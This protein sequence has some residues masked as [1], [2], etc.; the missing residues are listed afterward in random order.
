MNTLV[1]YFR[2]TPEPEVVEDEEYHIEH[3]LGDNLSH[4]GER[5]FLHLDHQSFVNCKLVSKTWLNFTVRHRSMLRHE[6]RFHQYEYA[7]WGAGTGRLYWMGAIIIKDS[8]ATLLQADNSMRFLEAMCVILRIFARCRDFTWSYLPLDLMAFF[9]MLGPE[10]LSDFIL[11]DD[12]L[13]EDEQ[14]QLYRIQYESAL[15]NNL[16]FFKMI[17]EFTGTWNPPVSDNNQTILHMDKVPGCFR[18]FIMDQ[19]EDP[20][21]K[22][23][24]GMT[25][26]HRFVRIGHPALFSQ[27]ADKLKININ[28]V[29]TY[30]GQTPLHVFIQNLTFGSRNDIF[31]MLETLLNYGADPHAQDAYGFSP[32]SWAAEPGFHVPCILWQ[33]FKFMAKRVEDLGSFKWFGGMNALHLAATHRDL[34]FTRYVLEET[35]VDIYQ[36]DD[37][38][39]SPLDEAVTTGQY[40]IYHLI[41]CEID[42]NYSCLVKHFNDLLLDS[43]NRGTRR[44]RVRFCSDKHKEWKPL[45]PD[46][47]TKKR[48]SKTILKE[49]Y[50]DLK[51]EH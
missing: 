29:K 14:N 35:N 39:F 4:I 46:Y 26:L 45:P 33:A 15:Q 47:K 21:P 48:G 5:I 40:E 11:D 24:L 20:N 2:R 43:K 32:L 30:S 8:L 42:K 17:V 37:H 16:D 13:E 50:D 49:N 28:D 18:A 6:L 44:L 23:D 41:H 1:R 34:E 51:H 19:V 25:P 7:N 27:T 38:G 9:H 31:P 3:F 36:E 12:P 10:K 22:D